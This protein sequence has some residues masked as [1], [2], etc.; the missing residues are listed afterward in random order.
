MAWEW[1]GSALTY[2]GFGSGESGKLSGAPE[3]EATATAVR[4][5]GSADS[6]G[7]TVNQRSSLGLPTAW[8]CV[9]L[10]SEV[11]GSMGMGVH[12]KANDGG[13]IDRTDHWLYDLVH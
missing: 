10:K 13:R 11:V 12:E 3:D 8:A 4:Y 7:Q 5:A 2:L 6:A 1:V 9:T